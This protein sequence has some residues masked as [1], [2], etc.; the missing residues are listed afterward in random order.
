MK[1]LVKQWKAMMVC[2][3]WPEYIKPVLA[4]GNRMAAHIERQNKQIARLK[5]ELKVAKEDFRQLRG[6]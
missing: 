2:R 6:K 4:I 5:A 1:S 3:W